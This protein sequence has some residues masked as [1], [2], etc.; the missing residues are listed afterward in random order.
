MPAS[1]PVADFHQTG[2]ITTLHRFPA[3]GPA[4]AN[5][6]ATPGANLPYLEAALSR[7]AETRPIALI[8]PCL[9]GELR[10]GSLPPM[11][12]AL[13]EVPYLEHVIVSVDGAPERHHF[14]EMRQAFAGLPTRDGRGATLVWTDGP[15]VQALLESLRAEGLETGAP[16]K[17]LAT[18]LATGF[19]LACGRARV[20][21]THDCD[22]RNY[23]RELLARLCFPIV[24]P[25]LNFEF[26][27]GY[28][29]R[30]TGRMYGRATRLLVTP[31][32]GALQSTLGPLPLLDYLQS[33]RYPLAGECAMTTDL[34]RLDPHPRPIGGSRSACSSE[35]YRATCR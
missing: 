13:R 1:A 27:K 4:P 29:P 17:G 24:H 30:V 3:G 5:D 2:K 35:V 31:F 11:I 34:A 28:Y 26:A 12:A 7:H 8:L 19:A 10:E 22:I 16:G 21:A 32:L 33:F 18:W 20:V 9:H 25:N 6:G 14:E 23:S 15:R